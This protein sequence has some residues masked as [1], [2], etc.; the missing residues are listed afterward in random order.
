MD[1]PVDDNYESTDE[2]FNFDADKHK[3]VLNSSCQHGLKYLNIFL[4]VRHFFS[5]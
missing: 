4:Y 5:I 2:Q 1:N 3:Q